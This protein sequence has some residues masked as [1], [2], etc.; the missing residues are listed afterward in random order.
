MRAATSS[1]GGVH[2]CKV[3]GNVEADERGHGESRLGPHHVTQ[4]QEE[5]GRR[6]A[7][8]EHVEDGAELGALA[9]CAGGH[10]VD[11]V[12]DEAEEVEDDGEERVVEGDGVGPECEDDA[13]VADEVGN[14]EPDFPRSGR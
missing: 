10:S 14:E 4:D 2:S 5:A 7:V 3:R 1:R 12:E 6:G 9:E 8:G 11:G 13:G